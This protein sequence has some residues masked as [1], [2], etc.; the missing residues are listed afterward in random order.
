MIGKTISR[1]FEQLMQLVKMLFLLY[2][3]QN[4]GL[5]EGLNGALLAMITPSTVQ[6]STLTLFTMLFFS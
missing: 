1:L 5:S 2:P 4:S 6:S 3:D